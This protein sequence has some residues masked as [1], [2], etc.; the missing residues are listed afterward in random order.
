MEESL[1]KSLVW[2][3]YRLALLFILIAPL[4]LLIWSLFQQL[5]SVQR[6]FI[7]YWRVS[8]LFLLTIYLL[9]PVW[10]VGY[11]TGFVARLLIPISLW[12]WLDLNDEIRDLRKTKFKLFLTAWRWGVT[13][14]CG[15]SAVAQIPFLSCF[16]APNPTEVTNCAVWLEAPWQYKS[17]MHANLNPGFLGFLGMTGLIFYIIYF[18]YFLLFRLIKQGRIALEQ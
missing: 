8:S 1:L 4:I 17:L 9:I 5:P 3:D 11:I 6:L 14:Y 7:I 12:F 2:T 13:V 10:N 16:L 15:L 18:T